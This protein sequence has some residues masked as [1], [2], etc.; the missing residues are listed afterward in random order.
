MPRTPAEEV[1]DGYIAVGRV[2]GAFGVKGDI[3]VQP[4][5][6]LTQFKPG[7]TVYL[8]GRELRV[9]RSRSAPKHILLK[10]EA[11]DDREDAASWR[12][13]YLLIA[14]ADLGPPGEDRYYH[15]QLIG[16]PVITTEGEDLGQITDIV[17]TAGNDV[18]VVHG[19]RGEVLIPAIE[20]VVR[21]ID[22]SVGRVTVEVLPGLLPEPKKSP[23]KPKRPPR[24]K[25]PEA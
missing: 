20:D 1:P 25:T 7:N 11:I 9:E 12:D 21:E 6:P 15:F 13:E 17:A 22:T 8:G 24:T 19:A 10:L 4:L 18:F 3:K 14:E 2:L 5:A 16:L 23:A